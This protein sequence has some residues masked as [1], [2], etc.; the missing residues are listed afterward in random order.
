MFFHRRAIVGWVF[1]S[2]LLGVV[3]ESRVFGQFPGRGGG[4]GGRGP[5]GGPGGRGGPPGGGFSPVDFLRRLDTNGN[6]VLDPSEQEGRAQ[7]ML[8]RIKQAVPQ[9]PIGR[10][11]PIESLGRAME[12]AREQGGR[13]P[14]SSRD[15]SSSGGSSSS[16]SSELEPLVPGFGVEM[17]LEPVLGFGAAGE[18]FSV[19][20]TERDRA[21]ADDRFRRYDR[22]GDGVLSREEISGGRWS[23]DPFQYDR[24]RDGKLSASEMSVRYANRRVKEEEERSQRDSNRDSRSGFS[25]RGGFDPRASREAFAGRGGGPG[26]GPG[27]RGGFSDRG[28]RGGFGDRGGRGG[29]S[30]RGGFSPR[31]SDSSA[32][33]SPF[34][35]R[36]RGGG[37]GDDA[38][39]RA[40]RI[41]EFMF[42]RYDTNG[43]GAIR[44]DELGNVRGDPTQYDKNKDKKITKEEM[45]AYMQERMSGAGGPR[46][47][48]GGRGRGGPFGS[49]GGDSGGG[50]RSGFFTRRDDSSGG[51]S[52]STSSEPLEV[53]RFLTPA[54]R[55]EEQEVELDDWFHRDDANADGQVVMAEFARDWDGSTLGD[56]NQWDVN[57]DGV[58]TP[59]EF[60]AAKEKG[61]VRGSSSGGYSSSSYASSR[62]DS[63]D[64]RSRRPTSTG[65]ASGASSSGGGSTSSSS[66][67]A[68]PTYVKYAVGVIKK[69]DTNGDGMLSADEWKS[70]S[71][72]PSSAD[73]DG[74]GK[75]TPD[76]YAVFLMPK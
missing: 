31:G 44:G 65:S 67:G 45:V 11:I 35:S 52:S 16:A 50:G 21:Q 61:A 64:R 4:P 57:R 37:G 1:L 40:A 38:G 69:Y 25:S 3:V 39:D 49:R 56:F 6:G 42:S 26:G 10:P 74:N 47:D 28:G 54:E 12:R 68:A 41:V 70:M 63:R 66:G 36:E 17:G 20:V 59:D 33:R 53:R 9:L 23:D 7:F 76:E 30:E 62:S 8:E 58:I 43:D 18:L 32:S 2:L 75:I 22:N 14:S 24:N 72:D 19:K 15:S 5:G 73:T 34:G 27:G 46:G 13:G 55:L 60:L 48:D 71:K 51:N 29:S